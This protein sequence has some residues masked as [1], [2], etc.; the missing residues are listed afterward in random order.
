MTMMELSR[1]VRETSF[2]IHRYLR[3][4][5]L[6]RVYANALAHRLR[7]QSI[8][9]QQEYPIE[10]FDEDGT[11]L[12]RYVADFLIENELI[13]ELKACRTIAPEHIAQVLGYLRGARLQHGML[14]NFG[15]SKLELKKLIL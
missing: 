13:V 7:K 12:G 1:I 9:L 11:P 4:G 3:S 6:E 14:V 2:S 5:H 8:E 10:I 15:A